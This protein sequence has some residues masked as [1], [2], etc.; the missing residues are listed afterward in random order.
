MKKAGEDAQ[1]GKKLLDEMKA[2]GEAMSRKNPRGERVQPYKTQYLRLCKIYV[3]AM[4]DH[5]R[6]K[7]NMRKAQTDTLVRR[8]ELVYGDTKSRDEIKAA[9][10]RDPGGFLQE[11]ILTEASAEAQQ[12]Y[13]DAQ[14]RARDVEMLVR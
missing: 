10:E 1:K 9:V 12:A 5:Q 6:A 2:K 13:A 3:E 7:E 14:S 11:A 8:G 4:K